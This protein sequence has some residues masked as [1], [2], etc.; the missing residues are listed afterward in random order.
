MEANALQCVILQA[1]MLGLSRATLRVDGG[2]LGRKESNESKANT[3]QP[4]PIVKASGPEHSAPRDVSE[5]PMCELQDAS[6]DTPERAMRLADDAILICVASSA[7]REALVKAKPKAGGGDVA[8][9]TLRDVMGVSECPQ[10][11][12]AD[13]NPG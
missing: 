8:R 9:P 10:S 3:R 11:E 1:D 13:G 6:D 5:T 12:T 4:T 2:M 7:D